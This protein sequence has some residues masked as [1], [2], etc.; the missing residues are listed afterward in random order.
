M[1]VAC[2]LNAAE[3][4]VDVSREGD[5]TTTNWVAESGVLDLFFL[6]GP[7]PRQVCH[8]SIHSFLPDL[9]HAFRP[10]VSRAFV[11]FFNDVRPPRFSSFSSLHHH[12]KS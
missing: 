10:A 6:L 11:P 12:M 4:F 9:L 3:M 8:S 1:H 7:T 5:S 2:R